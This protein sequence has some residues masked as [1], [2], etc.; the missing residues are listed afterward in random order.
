MNQSGKIN[1]A[2]NFLNRIVNSSDIFRHCLELSITK[3]NV[4]SNIDCTNRIVHSIN[5]NEMFIGT[6]VNHIVIRMSFNNNNN[7]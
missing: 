1:L 4:I 7:K 5:T 6:D 2:T 3:C